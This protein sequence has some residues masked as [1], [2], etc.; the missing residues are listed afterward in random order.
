[1]AVDELDR[2][3]CIQTPDT[4]SIVPTLFNQRRSPTSAAVN[5]GPLSKH[6]RRDSG[7]GI[8]NL[9]GRVLAR[10]PVGSRVVQFA[11]VGTPSY[12]DRS[13]DARVRAK[14]TALTRKASFE[15]LSWGQHRSF[16]ANTTSGG[17]SWSE[18]VLRHV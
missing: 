6:R 10:I 1:M 15:A 16:V 3:V 5:S 17:R 18:S 7:I 4:M 14:R 8:G 2:G 13:S 11:I 12:R 9:I